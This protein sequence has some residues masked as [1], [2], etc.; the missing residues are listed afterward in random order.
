MHTWLS[1]PFE[2][3]FPRECLVCTRP[4]HGRS[5]CFRCAPKSI[6]LTIPRCSQCFDAVPTST[7]TTCAACRGFPL[8]ADRVR[9]L[10]DYEGLA[11]DFI[12]TMKYKPSPYLA[13]LAGEY[14]TAALLPLFGKSSWDLI[15]PVPSSPSTVKKRFFHPCAEICKPIRHHLIDPIACQQLQH[16]GRRTPQAMRSRKERLRGV[17]E[18][19]RVTNPASVAGKR[20]LVVEDVIT[21]GATIAAACHELRKAGAHSIDV[22]ALAEAR[23][24]RRFRSRVFALFEASQASQSYH[25]RCTVI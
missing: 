8:P 10:W 22:V 24:W 7:D 1:G 6:P 23:I 12:R 11:R 2:V 14:L 4:L 25:L 21:T 20:V 3:L 5:L 15:I 9:Y 16:R 19:F 17:R 18:I 13:R